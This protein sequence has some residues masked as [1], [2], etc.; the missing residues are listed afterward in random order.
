LRPSSTVLQKRANHQRQSSERL[1]C[2]FWERFGTPAARRR[3]ADGTPAERRN[4]LEHF[5]MLFWERFGTPAER[6][7]NA[8][9]T[10]AERRR[11]AGGTPAERRRNGK[12]AINALFPFPGVPAAFQTVPNSGTPAARRR[13]GFAHTHVGTLMLG[14]LDTLLFAGGLHNR[15]PLSAAA[16]I[17]TRRCVLRKKQAGRNNKRHRGPPL[18]TPRLSR[19]SAN[20]WRHP[21]RTEER[22]VPKKSA[23]PRDVAM[24][25]KTAG[26][27]SNSPRSQPRPP[28]CHSTARPPRRAAAS[29]S[30][31]DGASTARRQCC[32]HS[33]AGS[34]RASGRPPRWC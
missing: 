28:A 17:H 4:A 11:N 23:A 5:G 13:H 14:T 2:L 30:A 26:G 1:T 12:N 33:A 22:T 34:A 9:G 29:A 20:R 15:L 24:P 6:R 25:E 27:E 10:P 8:G 18:R 7:W 3:N 21:T 19:G 32:T 16:I 31:A